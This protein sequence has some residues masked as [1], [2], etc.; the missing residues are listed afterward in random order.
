[1]LSYF[2]F[3]DMFS[4]RIFADKLSGRLGANLHQL[5]N[6]YSF[7]L[8]TSRTISGSRS[9]YSTLKLH[10]SKN[11]RWE[12]GRERGGR[13]KSRIFRHVY[14]VRRNLFQILEATNPAVCFKFWKS[15][16]ESYFILTFLVLDKMW[17]TSAGTAE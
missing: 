8:I 17:S 13:G 7:T 10:D 16:M 2:Q 14:T 11:G 5:Y 12:G 4:Y 1:M 3:V 6:F 15:K 9:H